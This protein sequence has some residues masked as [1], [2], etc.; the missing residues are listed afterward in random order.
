M[1]SL[2]ACVWQH[3]STGQELLRFLVS[4]K[5]PV[6][7]MLDLLLP[8]DSKFYPHAGNY[9]IV[10]A[11]SAVRTS[12]VEHG[13]PIQNNPIIFPGVRHDL[14]T[15]KS[16]S[17]SNGIQRALY[18]CSTGRLIGSTSNPLKIGYAGLLMTTKGPQLVVDSAIQLSRL[19][20]CVQVSFA[21][22]EFQKGLKQ[23]FDQQFRQLSTSSA[24][25]TL[26][27]SRTSVTFLVS[28]A[29]RNFPIHFPEAFGIVKAEEVVFST[30]LFWCW[31][32]FRVIQKWRFW[33]NI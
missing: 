3:R 9:L 16:G 21:G 12:L 23:Y 5:I 4:T 31:W 11:S 33:L 29:Y 20:Y 22:F 15:P 13:F 24:L 19:G 30:D 28:T 17:I 2:T 7:I 26:Q 14:F 18:L 10:G 8:F 25:G 6:V 27:P 32:F 1:T